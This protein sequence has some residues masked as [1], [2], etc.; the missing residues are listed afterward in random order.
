MYPNYVLFSMDTNWGNPRLLRRCIDSGW[1][2]LAG[3][4][5]SK[6]PEQLYRMCA[7]QLPNIEEFDSIYTMAAVNAS[8]GC[9]NLASLMMKFNY[10]KPVET[11]SISYESVFTYALQL[12]GMNP[13]NPATER[14]MRM[15]PLV[16]KELFRQKDAILQ[17]QTMNGNK[18]KEIQLLRSKWA[19]QNVGSLGVPMNPPEAIGY[20]TTRDDLER[21]IKEKWLSSYYDRKRI[22]DYFRKELNVGIS[23]SSSGFLYSD[24]SGEISPIDFH[25]RTQDNSLI[26]LDIYRWIHSQNS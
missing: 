20:N 15:H 18:M 6:S 10:R 26:R 3:N 17:L 1:S 23:L 9:M 21:F 22:K 25:S 4:E 8:E 12:A 11:A 24:A 5:P 14:K 16:Q 19:N 2:W 13:G 7:R